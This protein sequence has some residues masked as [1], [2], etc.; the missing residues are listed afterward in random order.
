MDTS[1]YG[2]GYLINWARTNLGS[3]GR[4]A[5]SALIELPTYIKTPQDVKNNNITERYISATLS[6]LK[7]IV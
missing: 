7:G 1:T 2:K 6:M 5:R 4:A 3:N